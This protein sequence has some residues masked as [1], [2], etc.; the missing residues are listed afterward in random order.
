MRK[1]FEYDFVNKV[2]IFSIRGINRLLNRRPIS[3]PYLSGDTFRSI[4][5]HIFEDS[6]D[7]VPLIKK[8]KCGDLIFCETHLLSKFQECVLPNI[9]DKFVLITHNSDVNVTASLAPLIKSCFL[10]HWFAQNNLLRDEKITTIP[11]GLENLWLN[12]NGRVSEFDEIRLKQATKIPRIL[13]GFNVNTNLAERTLALANLA[14]CSVADKINVNSCKYRK[15]LNKYMFVASPSGNGIDCH[16]TWEAFYFDVVPIVVR[17]D[18]Y[19]SLPDFAGLLLNDWGEVDNF[20]EEN[21]R[22]IYQD[23]IVKIRA[24]KSLFFNYW[25]DRIARAVKDCF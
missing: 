14:K 4:A 19:G 1:I 5:N 22:L 11:I 25:K 20:T 10:Q 8:F 24:N 3:D 12:N 18:F 9:K 16:R 21:L 15:A 23:K 2:R 7:V 6:L 17:S 13:Y